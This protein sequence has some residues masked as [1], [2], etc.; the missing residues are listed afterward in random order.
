MTNACQLQSL[1]LINFYIVVFL[2]LK[3]GVTQYELYKLK[4]WFNLIFK[5]SV[6]GFL[7]EFIPDL[8]RGRNDRGAE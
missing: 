5:Y 4:V 2:S 1:I 3:G 8:I 7:L 6:H